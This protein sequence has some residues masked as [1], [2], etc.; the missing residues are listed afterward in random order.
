PYLAGAPQGDGSS[1]DPLTGRVTVGAF[2]GTIIDAEGAGGAEEVVVWR[3]DFGAYADTTALL[4]AW[5]ENDP[6]GLADFTL[7]TARVY[8]AAK[9]VL[10]DQ[11]GAGASGAGV[12]FTL[13]RQIAGLVPGAAYTQYTAQYA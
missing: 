2:V 4:A 5:T 6:E 12:P 7:S 8:E 10:V 13:D 9:S 1:V 11:T 3:E